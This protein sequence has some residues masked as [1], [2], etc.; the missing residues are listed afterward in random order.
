MW[1][2]LLFAIDQFESGQTALRFTSELAARTG[3]QVRVLHIRQLSKWARVPP[4]E[5]IAEADSLVQE[6]LLRLQLA[7]VYADGLA[8]SAPDD[9]VAAKIFAEAGSCM[10]DAIVLGSR[11]LHGIERL[12]G[13]SVRDKLLR[14]TPLPIVV[15]PTPLENAIYKPVRFRAVS[16]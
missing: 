8:C 6:A 13:R 3:A 10:C 14:L 4:L 1:Q 11:R 12:S 16:S 15:A 5:T 2:R 9:F 7:G